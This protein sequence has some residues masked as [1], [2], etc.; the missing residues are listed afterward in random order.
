MQDFETASWPPDDV[1]AGSAGVDIGPKLAGAASDSWVWLEQ[2]VP[3]AGPCEM[4][5]GKR[6][7]C[8]FCFVPACRLRVLQVEIDN[9][10]MYLGTIFVV[11]LNGALRLPF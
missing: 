4:G 5:A 11:E 2:Q 9:D 3:A 7:A 6:Q 10:E 1:T 8:T